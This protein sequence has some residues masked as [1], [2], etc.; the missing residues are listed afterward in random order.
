MR[1]RARIGL[2]I[3]GLTLCLVAI[4]FAAAFGGVLSSSLQVPVVMTIAGAGLVAVSLV[5]TDRRFASV[6]G[7]VVLMLASWVRLA[8]AG[9]EAVEAYTLPAGLVLVVLGAIRMVRQPDSPSLVVLLPG[10]ALSLLPSLWVAV[11]EPTSQ[12]ALLL[13]IAATAT[14]LVGAYL[15]WIAPLLMGAGVVLVLAGVNLAPY[16]AAV[17]RWV[18]FALLGGGLLFLGIT[19]EKR[20][21]NARTLIAAAERLA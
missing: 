11:A 8:E 5:S 6:A 12:R 10:L 1:S 21:R 14:L 18:L 2:E 13:G 19:W 7:G 4:G 20:L 16:A 3:A 15:R 9:V 17:P